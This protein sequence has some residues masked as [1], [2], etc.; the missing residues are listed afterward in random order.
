MFI[1]NVHSMSIDTSGLNSSIAAAPNNVSF[2]AEESKD[3]IIT[4]N[5]FIKSKKHYQL[6]FNN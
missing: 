1:V 4:I 3:S 6:N 5:N 2:K